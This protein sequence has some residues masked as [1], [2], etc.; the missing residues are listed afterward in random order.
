MV[1]NVLTNDFNG[2]CDSSTS[3]PFHA[4]HTCIS[5]FP[6]RFA[7]H[8]CVCTN[9]NAMRNMNESYI[10]FTCFRKRK[11]TSASNF[12]K[13]TEGLKNIFTMNWIQIGKS[14]T[15]SEN[16]TRQATKT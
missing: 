9:T 8:V 2:K 7:C 4:M 12:L 3:I 11:Q 13:K 1:V 14:Y 5:E 15:R 10:K 16:R 6:H